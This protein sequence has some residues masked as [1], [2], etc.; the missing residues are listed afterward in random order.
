MNNSFHYLRGVRAEAVRARL[1]NGELEISITTEAG[2][3]LWLNVQGNDIVGI[4]RKLG[5]P[6]VAAAEKL[7]TV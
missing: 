4:V 3:A 6:M 7:E 2:D 1:R 5:N